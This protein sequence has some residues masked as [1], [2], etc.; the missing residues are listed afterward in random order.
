MEIL[1]EPLGLA[2]LKNILETYIRTT[3]NWFSVTCNQNADKNI[4]SNRRLKQES[5]NFD[6]FMVMV[7][8]D[9]S[10]PLVAILH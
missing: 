2:S 8:V 7:G 5:P 1:L 4:P 3:L 9:K 10:G 6:G